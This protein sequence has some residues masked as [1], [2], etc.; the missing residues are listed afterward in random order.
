MGKATV[1]KQ[2]EKG[3]QLNHIG[4]INANMNDIQ[5]EA[6]YFI[7]ACYG[8]P[9]GSSNMSDV[10]YQ[11]WL[12][13]MGNKNVRKMPKLQSLPPTTE[14]FK[15]N[16]KRAHIQ[17]CVWKSALEPEPPS[18]DVTQYG[19]IKDSRSKTLAP[20]TVADDK[21][22]TPACVLKLISCG[23]SSQQPCRT[24]MVAMAHI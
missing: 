14:S 20:V 23:C 12:S 21:P 7:A 19:W 8:K 15:E 1:V 24:A 3:H 6:T 10:R 18:L 11:V 5:T 22:P 17:A 16:L 4:N 13:K 2:L 9:S